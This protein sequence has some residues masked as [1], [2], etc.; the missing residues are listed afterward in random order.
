MLSEHSEWNV[1]L[2]ILVPNNGS[3]REMKGSLI[4]GVFFGQ[5]CQSYDCSLSLCAR[6]FALLE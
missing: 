5:I 1:H 3:V 4:R 2:T 6:Y